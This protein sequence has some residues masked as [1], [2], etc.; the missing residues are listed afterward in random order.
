MYFVFR[1]DASNRIGTGHIMRCLVLADALKKKG[2]QTSFACQCLVGDL[3]QYIEKRGHGVIRLDSVSNMFV[4]N[5]HCGYESWLQRS[6]IEDAEDFLRH[7]KAADVVVTDHYA[8]GL[9]WHRQIRESLGCKIVAIDDLVREHEADIVIDQTLGRE[10]KEYCGEATVL[11]G[12]Q[13][14]LLAPI[15]AKAREQAFD[16][17]SLNT[18]IKILISMGGVDEPN[19]TQKVLNVLVN[20]S[21]VDITVL[22]SP[23]AP[24]YNTVSAFC[25]QNDKVKH[26]DFSENMADLMLSHD[27]AIGAPGTTSWERACLGIPSVLISLAENQKTNCEKL[28]QQGAV[29]AV[30]IDDI[31]SKLL[32]AY[33]KVKQEWLNYRISNLKICDGLGLNRIMNVLEELTNISHSSIRLRFADESDIAMVYEWQCL[34]ET[35]RYALN[36]SIPTWN[37][38]ITWMRKKLNSHQDYFY[39]ITHIDTNESLGVVRLDRLSAYNYLISIFIDPEHYGKGIG[40]C[41]LKLIDKTHRNISIHARVL[42]NNLASQSLFEKSGYE[43]CSE[44]TFLRKILD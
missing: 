5:A 23:R 38:H 7:V 3:I 30:S 9:E 4:K 17:S 6:Q 26:I 11:A 16:I 20:E 10:A 18:P 12:S 8:I 37:E 13:Y 15:Y 2:Y 21:S 36:T 24:N 40:S 1:A 22:L 33:R 19:V 14:S 29:E 32:L 42:K 28:V 44:E 39:I 34:P 31:E 43:R 35:R 27:I 25:L 41:T